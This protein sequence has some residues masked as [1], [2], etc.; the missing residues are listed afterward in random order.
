MEFLQAMQFRHATKAFDKTKQVNQENQKAILEFARLSPSSFGLEP[1]HFLVVSQ[2]DLREQIKLACWNQDQITSS[3][4]IV[5]LLSY[6]PH[7]F[8]ANSDF[9]RERIF[10]KSLTEERYRSY[11]D[12]VVSYLAAQNTQEW[13]KRQTYIALANMM[14]GAASLGVDSCPIEGFEPEK[15]KP[16][17]AKYVDWNKFDLSVIAA[18]G[19]RAK[20][21]PPLSREPSVSVVT[22]L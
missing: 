15:L 4:F 17:L 8:R 21:Q 1:W 9:L 19:H 12:L 18:F 10:R 2:P 5:I 14:T 6:L 16:V 11:H 7:H 3:S 22:Y 13:A 20:D